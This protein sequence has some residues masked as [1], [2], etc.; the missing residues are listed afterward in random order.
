MSL[1]CNCPDWKP[2]IE[3]INGPFIL[4]QIRQPGSVRPC[5]PFIFCPWCSNRL[6]EKCD[7]CGA[8]LMPGEMA[9]GHYVEGPCKRPQ[10]SVRPRQEPETNKC[11]TCGKPTFGLYCAEH[12]PFKTKV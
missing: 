11:R 3:I 4:Q 12:S 7:Q 5:K 9:E 1:H 6:A 8:L 2:N 10:V